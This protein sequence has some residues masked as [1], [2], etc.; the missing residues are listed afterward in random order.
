MGLLDNLALGSFDYGDQQRGLLA[1]LQNLALVQSQTQATPL[2]SP[3]PAYPIMPQ[4]FP[5]YPPPAISPQ[6]F[7][8]VE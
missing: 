2:P 5:S 3:S 1:M 4:N 6:R 7:S 8:D